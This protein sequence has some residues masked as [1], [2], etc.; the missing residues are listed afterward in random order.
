MTTLLVL[1]FMAALAPLAYGLYR[2]ASAIRS[3][4]QRQYDAQHRAASLVLTQTR[5]L[6]A[7]Q[8]RA[9][10]REWGRAA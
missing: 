2:L 9:A 4:R 8:A 6:R 1:A 10:A 7:G 3:Y 5:I